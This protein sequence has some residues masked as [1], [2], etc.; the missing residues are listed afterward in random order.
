[1]TDS[2]SRDAAGG[3]RRDFLKSSTALAVGGAL[4]STLSIGR[5]AHAAGDDT[6]KIALIGCGGRGTGA[7]GDAMS[8]KQNL[9]VVALADAFRDRLDGCYNQ[10]KK[11][12]DRVEV[13]EDRKFVGVDAYQKAIDS[14]IDLAIL[15]TPPGFRPIHLAAAVK[16]GKH[17][18]MEK[19]VATEQFGVRSVLESAA[20]AKKKGL[21]IGVGLQR[22]HQNSYIETIKRIARRRDRRCSV[23]SRVLE[24]RRRVGQAAPT[25]SDRNG[26]PGPQLVLL[27]LAQRRRNLRAAHP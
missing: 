5:S 4:A 16:A 3:T 13:P 11:F 12:G 6:I 22:R 18:F 10:L 7:V 26:I 24:R 17:V 21:A 23:H 14:G 27:R 2:I 15:A 19:P 8:T 25:G 9:K 1:M 20:E